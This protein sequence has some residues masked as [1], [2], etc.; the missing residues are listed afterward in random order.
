M[1]KMIQIEYCFNCFCGA[2]FKAQTLDDLIEIV[3]SHNELHK[4]CKM[5]YPIR[6]QKISNMNEKI[7]I[8]N[9][10]Y[11]RKEVEIIEEKQ[12]LESYYRFYSI[13]R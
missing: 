8:G 3:K 11:Y 12:K 5:P 6:S 9:L 7:R 4:I 2:F 10:L 1:I 13:F